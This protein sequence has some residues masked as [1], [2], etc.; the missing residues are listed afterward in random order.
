MEVSTY[1][2][3][4]CLHLIV[5]YFRRAIYT[6]GALAPTKGATSAEPKATAGTDGTTITVWHNALARMSTY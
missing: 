5:S 2:T 1:L 4:P 3:Y 6:D